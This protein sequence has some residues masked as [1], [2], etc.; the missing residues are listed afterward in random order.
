MPATVVK[1]SQTDTTQLVTPIGVGIG[2]GVR[3]ALA[4][5]PREAMIAVGVLNSLSAGI[6]VSCRA[7]FMSSI[8]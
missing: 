3:N 5:N 4:T 7:Y 6:L 1:L 8:R 2:I